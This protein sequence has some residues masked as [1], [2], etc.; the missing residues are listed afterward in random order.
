MCLQISI[1]LCITFTLINSITQMLKN[2][3]FS[4]IILVNY[5]LLSS[6]T[7]K[8]EG[9]CI[10]FMSWNL[11]LTGNFRTLFITYQGGGLFES[12]FTVTS[13]L[14]IG[15]QICRKPITKDY[16]WQGHALNENLT[17]DNLS[18]KKRLIG[19]LSNE[20]SNKLRLQKKD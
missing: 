15:I 12:I 8:N 16:F 13:E 11:F 7:L 4:G 17:Y 10:F 19:E 9:L 3:W 2:W 20:N 18:S 1:F 5:E 6:E 14:F